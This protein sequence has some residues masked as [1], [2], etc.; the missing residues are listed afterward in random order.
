MAVRDLAIQPREGDLLVATHG[1]GIY[2]IDDLT[3]LRSLTRERLSA[4]AAFLPARPSTLSIPRQEQRFAGSAAWS[5]DELPEA[6]IITYYLKKRH[7]IGDLKLEVFDDA[8]K[9][10]ATI[11]GGRRRGINRVEWPMRLKGPKVPRAANLVPNQFALVGPR[12]AAGTYTAKLTRNKDTYT[13]TFTLVGDPRSTH[14]AS[15]RAEQVKLVNRLYARLGDLTYTVESVQGVRD[16]ARARAKTLGKD[17]LATKLNA[18]ADRLETFRGTLVA[19]KEGGRLTGEEHLRE[20]M[21]DLY[22]KVN[23]YDGRPTNGQI[24]LAAV[25]D[26]ELTKGEADFAAI[27]A[28]DLPKLEREARDGWNKRN[29]DASPGSGGMQLVKALCSWLGVAY[30]EESD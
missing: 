11:N 16:T 4:D 3:P 20:Q 28:K 25:L 10:L 1:R 13:T 19:A 12:A 21:G 29:E 15:D 27:L 30:E 23:G 9:K 2:V 8:G 17:A 24:A 18:F 7:L 5:G 6:A 22:G 14:T 26:G